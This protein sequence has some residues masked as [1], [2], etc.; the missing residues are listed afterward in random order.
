MRDSPARGSSSP[1]VSRL[2]LG[3]EH[4]AAGRLLCLVAWLAP[5]W[6]AC[7]SPDERPLFEPALAPTSNSD[8]CSGGCGA[9]SSGADAGGGALHEQGADVPAPG[10][11]GSAPGDAPGDA[12]GSAPGDA[13]GSA[14][15]DASGSAPGDAPADG[16]CV[17]GGARCTG[18]LLEICDSVLT[19]WRS[20]TCAASE[21]CNAA[22]RSCEPARCEAE[23]RGCRGAQPQ[24]CAPGRNGFVDTGMPCASAE[25][26]DPS[27]GVCVQPACAVGQ[28]VCDGLKTLLTCNASQT[29]FDAAPCDRLLDLCT[30]GPPAGCRSLL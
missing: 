20:S 22:T 29:G 1:E 16:A 3:A 23:E 5:C 27:S 19:G 8:A 9:S 15:G 14:P 7:S 21:L 17:V 24:R 25:L 4:R 18:A 28:T 11:V 10:A 6:A 13:S 2:N 12:P 30:S 26:C